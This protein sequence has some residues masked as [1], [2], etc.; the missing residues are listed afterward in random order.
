MNCM[1]SKNSVAPLTLDSVEVG[2]ELPGRTIQ[3]SRERLVEYAAA[4]G[5]R[6]P[7]HWNEAFATSVGLPGVIAHGMFT[8]GSAVEVVSAWA[9]AAAVLEYGCKF[10]APV[11][12]GDEGAVIHVT[13]RVTKVDGAAHR[14]VVELTVTHGGAKVLGR[15]LATVALG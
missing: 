8:M 2:Q 13:G 1:N 5:D 9:G 4:S 7:I 10:V 15:A 12:V 6:N 14:A 3:V 11:P